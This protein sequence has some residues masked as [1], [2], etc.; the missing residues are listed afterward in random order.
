MG[1]EARRRI[2]FLLLV[3]FFLLLP[4]FPCF[5]TPFLETMVSQGCFLEW[6]SEDRG[7]GSCSAPGFPRQALFFLVTAC[8]SKTSLSYPAFRR[9]GTAVG[10][11]MYPVLY[12]FQQRFGEA[13]S[14]ALTLDD[15]SAQGY[16]AF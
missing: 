11:L 6:G 9:L 16:L 7:G 10:G 8:F 13:E 15:V 4:I 1:S 12:P 3:L 14:A 5:S 2:H